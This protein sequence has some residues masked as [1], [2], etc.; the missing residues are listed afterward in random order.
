M[1]KPWLHRHALY[2]NHMYCIPSKGHVVSN[3]AGDGSFAAVAQIDRGNSF[4]FRKF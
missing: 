1:Q 2:L 3:N 4:P